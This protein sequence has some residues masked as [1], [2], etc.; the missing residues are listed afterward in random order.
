MVRSRWPNLDGDWFLDRAG[1][2]A[3]R[4]DADAVLVFDGAAPDGTVGERPLAERGRVVGTGAGSADD[5]I[6]D[7]AGRLAALGRPVWLVTS[8]RGLRARVDAE[9]T[10]GGGAFAGELERLE[11]PE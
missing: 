3:V 4:E 6:A 5:W 7:E 1:A 9:R 11:F 8:D 2:W 10:I